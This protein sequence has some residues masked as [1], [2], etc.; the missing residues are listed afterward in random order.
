MSVK[1]YPLKFVKLSNYVSSLMSSSRDEMSRFVTSVSKDMEEE[2]WAFTLHYN[3]D[4]DRLMVHEE[5][6]EEISRTK[7]GQEVKKHMPSIT[8]V[9]TLV[10]L[11]LETKIGPSSRRGTS[12]QVILL[13]LKTLMLKG[14]SLDTR[15]AMI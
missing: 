12:T 5:H 15:R 1:E 11:R 6:V 2:C 8:L 14:T 7:R 10:G 13:L 3:M 9:L 4:L